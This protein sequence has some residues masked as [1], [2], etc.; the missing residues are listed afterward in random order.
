VAV[1]ESC[2]KERVNNLS[3]HSKLVSRAC[4]FSV[5]H[6]ELRYT[7]YDLGY[8]ATLTTDSHLQYQ[9]RHEKAKLIILQHIKPN[10]QTSSSFSTTSLILLAASSSSITFVSQSPYPCQVTHRARPFSPFSGL[11][12]N[13]SNRDRCKGSTVYAILHEFFQA[14]L[15][16]LSW[17]SLSK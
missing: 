17:P 14:Q 16:Q 9:T 6:G 8:H 7:L 5:T 2:S 10:I 13:A 1:K 12:K 11:A 15:T 3:C 4:A